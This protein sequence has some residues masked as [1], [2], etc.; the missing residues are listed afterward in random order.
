[1]QYGFLYLLLPG[2]MLGELVLPT[3]PPPPRPRPSPTLR[4]YNCLPVRFITFVFKKSAK[5]YILE[6]I[7]AT[8]KQHQ[9]KTDRVNQA[10]LLLIIPPLLSGFQK[11]LDGC[12]ST[13]P[14]FSLVRS[15]AGIHIYI[16]QMESRSPGSSNPAIYLQFTSPFT[17]IL[18]LYK[19]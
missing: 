16:F 11:I 17:I 13:L 14:R 1:M 19:K 7:R 18:D 5:S 8:I 10:S 6:K 4:L 15:S 2:P 9:S 12:F 3:P